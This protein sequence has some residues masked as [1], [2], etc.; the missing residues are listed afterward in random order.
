MIKCIQIFSAVLHHLEENLVEQVLI[1]FWTYKV[2][3]PVCSLVL[4]LV[5][6]QKTGPPFAFSLNAVKVL[7]LIFYM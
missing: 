5:F 3:S 6:G 1:Y 7:F 4:D 2:G